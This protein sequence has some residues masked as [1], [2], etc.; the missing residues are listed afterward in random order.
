M[1][2]VNYSL[3]NLP[4][5]LRDALSSR[6]SYSG[7]AGSEQDLGEF[8][9]AVNGEEAV[10]LYSVVRE[11]RPTNTGEIGFCCGG[12]G[13]SILQ[14]LEDNQSGMHHACDPY[15]TPF[16]GNRGLRNVAKAGLSAR[17]DFAEK[18]P[19]EFFPQLP[20]LQF[21]FIDASHLFDLSTM[22]FVL[23]DKRLE[24]GGVLAFHDL[25]MPSLQKLFRF[26]V[27]NRNYEVYRPGNR[28]PGLN[29]SIRARFWRGIATLAR[30]VP[31]SG[32]IFAPE[33]LR[34]WSSF[35][36]NNVA[37][38]RKTAADDRAFQHFKAF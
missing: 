26:I 8:F 34:H 33:L 35:R 28:V 2:K 31:K 5:L 25:W 19:E 22:D 37:Y 11:L 4:E 36:S 12:S 32:R 30:V 27:A 1:N 7:G 20:P 13:I 24:V 16:A 18:F 3:L 21:V 14:A 9:D 17:L 38:F 23:A 6:V 29:P 10:E 15:Q